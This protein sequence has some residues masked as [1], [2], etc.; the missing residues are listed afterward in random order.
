MLAWMKTI[1]RRPRHR[2]PD[3]SLIRPHPRN[4]D[5][6]DY[7]EPDG[8]MIETYVFL[9]G[10]GPIDR[11]L[12]TSSLRAW[13]SPNRGEPVP[14]ELQRVIVNKFRDYFSRR[15]ISYRMEEVGPLSLTTLER[16]AL[17]GI[18]EQCPEERA[19]LEAQLATATVEKRENSG[20]GFFTN[21]NVDP[22]TPRID[23]R[24][25]LGHVIAKVAGFRHP[26]GLMLFLDGG[27]AHLL[28]G[29][30]VGG[31][32]SLGIDWNAVEFEIIKTQDLL[33]DRSR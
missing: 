31:D 32:N 13:T 27:Y 10:K 30:S 33:S 14:P 19:A 20:A 3:G 8:R 7:I 4:R 21:L 15:G 16:A 12:V 1:F 18:C 5:F 28:E 6:F 23:A 25:P 22:N 2:F 17:Q 11:V 9:T 24:S 26:L 29:Y